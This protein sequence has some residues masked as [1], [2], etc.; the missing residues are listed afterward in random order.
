MPEIIIYHNG[1]CSKSRGALELLQEQ[2][3]PHTVRWYLQEPLSE[4]E[5]AALL[6]Q[7]QMLP[8]ALVRKNEP[9]YIERFAGEGYTESEW[10]AILVENAVLIERPIVT[11]GDKAVI[12]RPAER[13]FEIITG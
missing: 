6:R 12:A 8:S 11:C 10:L 9:L 1:E 2:G 13:M 5:L 7:L 4:E 3:I